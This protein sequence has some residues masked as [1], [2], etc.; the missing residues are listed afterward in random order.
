ME[1]RLALVT[2]QTLPNTLAATCIHLGAVAGEG[3]PTGTE[4]QFSF[5]RQWTNRSCVPQSL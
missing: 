4:G 5:G 3:R 2:G 1:T